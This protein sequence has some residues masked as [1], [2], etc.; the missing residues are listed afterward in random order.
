L[1]HNAFDQFIV[2]LNESQLV[3]LL[4]LAGQLAVDGAKIDISNV[5]STHIHEE[6][7]VAVI[8]AS[9]I[10]QHALSAQHSRE[11]KAQCLAC[12]LNWV[13]YAQPMWPSKP[14]ALQYLRHLVPGLIGLLTDGTAQD[15]AMD[16]FR[17]ILESYTSFFTSEHIRM[18]GNLITDNLRPRMLQALQDQEPEVL[19]VAQMVIAYGIANVQ[20]IV[21][22]PDDPKASRTPLSLIM[23]IMEAPGY[24][25]DDDEVSLHSIEFWNTYIEYVNDVAYSNAS[26]KTPF[27][28][29]QSAKETCMTLTNLLWQKMRTPDVE[30]A[31][32][33]TDAESEGFKEF[34]MD[35]SDLMLS[36]YVFLGV[37]M[38]QQLITIALNALE[39]QSWQEMEAALFCINTLADNV[40]E[41]QLAENTLLQIFR[42]PLFRIVGDF[43]QTMPTQARRTAVDTLGAYGAYIERHAE[44]LPDTLRFLFASLENQGLYISAAKSIASLC[45]T[46]RN[47][48]TGELDGFLD[49]YNRFAKSESSEPYT[50]EK[51]IG[52]IAAIIQAVQPESAKAAPLSSLLDIVD[53]MILNAKQYADPDME[54]VGLSAIECL[55]GIGKN[56]QT[57]DDSPIDLYEDSPAPKPLESFWLGEQ[58]QAIQQRILN[59]CQNVLQL[60][61]A[62]SGVV[63][64]VCRVLKSGFTETQPGPFV[65]PPSHTVAFLEQCTISTPNVEAVL[66]MT[67]TLIHHYSRHDQPRIDAEVHRIYVHT[68]SF[69]QALAEPSTDPGVAQSCI[70]VFNRMIPRYLHVLLD[71]S[72]A[73]APLQPI[74][75]FAIHA[76]DG[77]DLMPKRSAA[78][79]WAR[80]VKPGVALD[81]DDGGAARARL[82]Q[83]VALYGPLL[84]RAL[85]HQITGRGQRSEL[86]QLCEPLKAL[87]YTRPQAKEWLER[88]LEPIHLETAVGEPEKRR[89]VQSVVGVRGETRKTRELVKAFF[90]AC[91]GTVSSY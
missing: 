44:F 48:L 71:L 38:L 22:Q 39:S 78:D 45:S 47:S 62:S 77:T 7:E 53:N 43:N 4:W 91:R 70:D 25:G 88:A 50:N 1:S 29:V 15:D 26:I 8:D 69:V 83:V 9:K 46:C 19:A 2:L 86:E 36:I 84:T 66:A 81:D 41:D 52:A 24:P 56:L 14:E 85:V 42:S 75:D 23:A 54:V 10:M 57:D 73:G 11:T 49:Q 80:I 59:C 17:D 5:D 27:L 6:L 30:T 32:E 16:V 58:G 34:R 51:V 35:A 90:A 82:E 40:L 37:E 60:L 63:D 76:L 13:N 3:T 18:I 87:V 79:F 61:P 33:W 72:G 31:K 89:F 55:A 65:F 68:I 74:F 28:W 67:C 20:Q 21:E 64:G 12:F